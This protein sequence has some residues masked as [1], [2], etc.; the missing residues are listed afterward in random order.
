MQGDVIDE[1]E[2]NGVD[3]IKLLK[4]NWNQ[5]YYWSSTI[6]FQPN[7]DVRNIFPRNESV[8]GEKFDAILVILNEVTVI[9]GMKGRPAVISDAQTVAEV[10]QKEGTRDF[11]LLLPK[12]KM[13]FW[14]FW[15]S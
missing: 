13:N 7:G 1:H 12:L 3:A 4:K 9:D 10:P 15:A 2:W 6:K 11:S 5:N 14:N 8:A